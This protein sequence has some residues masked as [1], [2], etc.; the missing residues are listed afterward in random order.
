MWVKR[1]IASIWLKQIRLL[2]RLWLTQKIQKK[3]AEQMTLDQLPTCL[4]KKTPP[5]L[6]ALRMGGVSR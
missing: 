3:L 2:K 4:D 6:G 1:L 5:F